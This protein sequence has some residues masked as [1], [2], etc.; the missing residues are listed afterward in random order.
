MKLTQE[1]VE[2]I[3]QSVQR[4]SYIR[5]EDFPNIP[6]YMD[7]VTSFIEEELGPNKR[8]PDDKVLTKTMIN[9][10]A[11][12]QLFPSPVKKKYTKDHLI[13][14]SI[15]Y[16]LK[17]FLSIN[18]IK[19]ILQNMQEHTDMEALYSDMVQTIRSSTPNTL[20]EITEKFNASFQKEN[21]SDSEALHLLIADLSYDIYVRKQIIERLVDALQKKE[22]AREAARKQ[23]KQRTEKRK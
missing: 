8:Y 4:I 15:I 22:A 3:L 2:Q 17:N 9:N 7:Q 11:K 10:Y 21:T 20:S 5:P 19:T 13:A 16:Y 23:N 18:D 6:L 12:N 14:F 1:E